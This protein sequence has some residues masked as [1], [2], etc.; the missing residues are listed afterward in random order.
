L[1]VTK[2]NLL[3]R[4]FESNETLL[5]KVSITLMVGFLNDC[6]YRMFTHVSVQG[7]EAEAEDKDEAML[8]MVTMAAANRG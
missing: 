4:G 8:Q 1:S 3:F 2:H 7:D 5:G 6:F